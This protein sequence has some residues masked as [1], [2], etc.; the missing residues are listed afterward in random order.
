MDEWCGMTDSSDSGTSASGGAAAPPTSQIGGSGQF[1]MIMMG[2]LTIMVLVDKN[3]RE[4]FGNLAGLVFYPTIGFEKTMPLI[5]LLC[6]GLLMTIISSSIRHYFTDWVEMARSQKILTKWNKEKR[7]AMLAQKTERQ[8][9]LNEK[10]MEM[11]QM[12]L[13]TMGSTLKPLAFTM[14]IIMSIFTWL[15]MFVGT[16]P[17][18]TFSVPWEFNASMTNTHL[19]PN[20][21]I[22]YS[23]LS[24]PF[25][26]L[27]ARLLKY[28]GFRR[29]L[30]GLESG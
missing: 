15:Y 9:K 23:A 1:L 27:F 7:E 2:L 10:A 5:T 28:P 26:Q 20:W 4:A 8:E 21:I 16:L 3:L 18:T 24:V 19:L 13:K 6:A 14:L 25:G 30:S 12:Q 22:L 17:S 11:N 29:R